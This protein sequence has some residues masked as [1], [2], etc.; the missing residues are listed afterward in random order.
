MELIGDSISCGL[1]MEWIIDLKQNTVNRILLGMNS[2]HLRQT[3]T[4]LRAE[5]TISNLSSS[6]NN[7]EFYGYRI[8][9]EHMKKHN[10][11]RK[12]FDELV[13]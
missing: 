7:I 8:Y 4:S 2:I 11:L 10:E 13:E 6:I 9:L 12:G 3:S 5:L 1:F